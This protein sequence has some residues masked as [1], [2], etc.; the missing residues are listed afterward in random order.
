MKGLPPTVPRSPVMH[1]S[2]VHRPICLFSINYAL[3]TGP[4]VEVGPLHLLLSLLI[5][6]ASQGR[7]LL[8]T[9]VSI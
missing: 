9:Q 5:M 2:P 6:A 1:P 7:L 4:S 8:V 3:A